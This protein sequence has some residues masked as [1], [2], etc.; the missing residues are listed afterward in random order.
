[1][2]GRQAT[3]YT[4]GAAFSNARG[5]LFPVQTVFTLVVFPDEPVRV[6]AERPALRFTGYLPIPE[7]AGRRNVAVTASGITRADD[8]KITVHARG[9]EGL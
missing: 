3:S 7:Q 8:G 4:C 5:M 2:E 1:M 6:D 9:M